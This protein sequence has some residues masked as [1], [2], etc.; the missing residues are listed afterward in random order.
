MSEGLNARYR[1]GMNEVYVPPGDTED[2]S[3]L[4]PPVANIIFVHGLCGHPWK[5]WAYEAVKEQTKP[6]WPKD[7][8][9][10]E[11]KNVRIYSFGYDADIEKFMSSA[12][13]N[14]V[15]DHGANLLN[16]LSFQ[17][18]SQKEKHVPF[19]FVVHSLGGLVLKEALNQSCTARDHRKRVVESTHGIIFLGTPHKGSSAASY[20]KIAVTLT[21]VFAAQSTNT[22]L[23][24][25]LE[26]G[27]EVLGRIE[28][29]F[30]ETWDQYGTIRI[31]SF[32][33]E[34]DITKLGVLRMRI[35]PPECAKIGHAHEVLGSIPEDHRYIAKYKDSR[36][37]GFVKIRNVLAK[38][39]C[40]IRDSMQNITMPDYEDCLES[41]DEP[42]ARARIRQVSSHHK[43]SFEWL[44]TDQVNFSKWLA[45]DKGE[46]SP[47]FWI[48]G[49]PGSGKSTLMRFA[50]QDPRL[51]SLA[52]DGEGKPLGYFFYL[53]GKNTAQKS[54]HGMLR[55]L[56]YQLL[57]QFPAYFNC[58]RP[59][60]ESLVLESRSKRPNWDFT[61]LKECLL[62][63]SELPIEGP[64]RS[65]FILFI[66]ALDEN[67]FAKENI[68]LVA[69]MKQLS[70]SFT[71]EEG[72][73]SGNILKICL[74]S[75]PWPLFQKA[76]GNNPR[77]HKFA[78]HE[79]TRPDIE[80]Y[81]SHHLTWAMS[82]LY[83]PSESGVEQVVKA[84]VE[85]AHGVF[86]WVR[87][88]VQHICQ[89]IID[90]GFFPNIEGYIT[91]LPEELDE[92]YRF[93]MARINPEYGLES[94]VCFRIMLCSLTQLTLKALHSA[95]TA[96]TDH[97]PRASGLTSLQQQLAW[98]KSRTGGLI[99]VVEPMNDPDNPL[100][101]LIHQTAQKFV[102]GGLTGLNRTSFEPLWLD[103]DGNYLIYTAI[104]N[105]GFHEPESSLADGSMDRFEYLRALD[106]A[107]DRD[108]HYKD[109]SNSHRPL[110]SAIQKHL[111][112]FARESSDVVSQASPN[113]ERERR[114]SSR[115]SPLSQLAEKK[116]HLDEP[117]YVM[118]FSAYSDSIA[119]SFYHTNDGHI[120][121]M[122][123]FTR[124]LMLIS[125]DLYSPLFWPPV[126]EMPPVTRAWL[127]FY[128]ALGPRAHKSHRTDRPRMIREI[129]EHSGLHIDDFLSPEWTAE[130][131][132]ALK[133]MLGQYD[134]RVCPSIGINLPSTLMLIDE[135]PLVNEDTR[136]QIADVLLSNG[137]PRT[138]IMLQGNN[139][140]LYDMSMLHFALR[141]KSK[142]WSDLLLSYG[143]ESTET[144]P[145][146]SM[147]M[148]PFRALNPSGLSIRDRLYHNLDREAGRSSYPG[149][150]LG[151]LVWSSIGC[152][153]LYRATIEKSPIK[154]NAFAL[155][156]TSKP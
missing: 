51:L 38:W 82:G 147:A 122:T 63:L 113:Q 2:G 76:F 104:L 87:I 59:H 140:E 46:F 3:N 134:A 117:S 62:S 73:A 61:S 57:L 69:I 70:D 5:T 66:D 15:H 143:A 33:E 12:G 49:K 75:R 28:K 77:I 108:N 85:K 110:H 94:L 24:R 139:G 44:F 92:L 18:E 148:L 47:I 137:A 144:G 86:I 58:I 99:E 1:N 56:V 22:K 19:I 26:K 14:S 65:R 96:C 116:I 95:T 133:E 142:K 10:N 11:L 90:G 126:I 60:Y 154:R 8:L 72:N 35:V 83:K 43:D 103:L 30:Y 91:T 105:K 20:G 45:D 80:G 36:D 25:T 153:E 120:G 152:A 31:Y 48:T 13:K 17:L 129:L 42:V 138:P 55:E 74:A 132:C 54:L 128:A 102:Q 40:E 16:D 136:L 97:L 141:F 114:Q 119:R 135:H 149:W 111:A 41:L 146:V 93:T 78:I 156:D 79:F 71:R 50:M 29:S 118:P 39:V 109:P 127:L 89:T 67:E 112:K 52:P 37:P 115:L 27:S 53:R 125:E 100:V 150:L 34:K 64:V 32:H 7:L 101:Q 4:P 6:F 88:V 145:A 81:T 151:A 124:A 84:V 9:P 68:E 23:L 107:L 98:L 130:Q 21:K 123:L 131:L 106:A 155:I 121:G